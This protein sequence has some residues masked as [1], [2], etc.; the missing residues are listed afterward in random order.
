MGVCVLDASFTFQWLFQDEASPSGDAALWSISTGGAVV[1]ALWFVEITNGLAM[2]ERR[3]RLSKA[4]ISEAL[5]LAATLLLA[6]DQPFSLIWH[7]AV[8]DLTR[9]HRLT[10]YD[11]TYLELTM[12]LGLPLATKDKDLRRA[13]SAVGVSLFGS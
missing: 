10:A 9:A 8:L 5:R 1:P 12:R 2:A 11:A 6:V 4:E 7:E 3:N 13:A